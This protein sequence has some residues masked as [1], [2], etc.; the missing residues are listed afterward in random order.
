MS[1]S[2]VG[3]TW[4]KGEERAMIVGMLLGV[5]ID[6]L[7]RRQERDEGGLFARVGKIFDLHVN[8]IPG[9]EMFRQKNRKDKSYF[10]IRS[11]EHIVGK[12][13]YVNAIG[14]IL[15]TG[16]YEDF[17]LPEERIE[18]IVAIPR[19][20]GKTAA[21]SEAKAGQFKM[22]GYRKVSNRHRI[23]SRID[24]EDWLETM[25]ETQNTSVA[26][27]IGP[28]PHLSLPALADHYRRCYSKDKLVVDEH[29]IKLMHSSGDSSEYV[30]YTSSIINRSKY[31]DGNI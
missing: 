30:G 23:V 20:A 13:T 1:R 14:E 10:N 11:L 25:A 28:H 31:Q 2:R 17:S 6:T 27:M 4:R 29:L 19:Q 15:L 24:C 5:P 21:H 22:S 3:H 12:E 9:S 26:E 16:L 7:A 8:Q 18:M